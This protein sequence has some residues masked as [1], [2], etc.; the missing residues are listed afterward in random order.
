LIYQFTDE[1]TT[2][3]YRGS[4][5]LFGVEFVNMGQFDTTKAGLDLRYLNDP[6]QRI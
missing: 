6:T 2:F 1:T 4:T 5:Q 3:T